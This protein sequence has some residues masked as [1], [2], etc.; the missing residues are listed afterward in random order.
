MKLMVIG[1]GQC[2]SRLVDEFCRVGHTAKGERKATIVT[3]A[4]TVNTDQADLTG[5]KYVKSDYLHRIVIG[6]RKTWGH[7][8]GKIN[9]LGAELAKIDGD[10]VLDAIKT[11]PAFHETHAFL[12]I[13]SAAGSTGSGA[14]GVIAQM[15]NER[16]I[17]KPL[18]A[19]IVL[20][21][22][23]EE[24]T[25]ERA[26]YNTATC[27]KTIYPIADG[28]FLAENQRYVRKDTSMAIN[29]ERINS[30][31]VCPFYDLLSAGEATKYKHI[32]AKTLDAGDIIQSIEGWTAIGFGRTELPVFRPLWARSQDFRKKTKETFRG[33]EA[34][35]AA[36]GDLSVTCDPADA[37]RALYL[38]SA[39][40]KEM[41]IDMAKEM[42]NYMRE[43]AS[44]AV[45]RSGDFPGEK[46]N[47]DVTVIFSGLSSIPKITDYYER[48]TAWVPIAKQRFEET[49]S[50]LQD[51]EAKGKD[52][53]TL[54]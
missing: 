32:G 34:M 38:L 3:G 13:A 10:K 39:P 54:L 33:T 46:S 49:K 1:L 28:V 48:A 27:L 2:G 53:P 21:F 31:I 20:P 35:D 51:M 43:L 36:I 30:Q 29:L 37:S 16:F 24:K 6:A 25:E 44:K 14:M 4:Y 12:V 45:I 7:G 40:A 26:V 22:E 17:G 52:L 50:R 15:I 11:S 8:V 18:Y 41:N 5:L 9:E 19:L 23:H 42:G 47:V